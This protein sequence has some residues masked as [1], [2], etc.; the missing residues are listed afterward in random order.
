MLADLLRKNLLEIARAYAKAEKMPISVVSRKTYGKSSF[1]QDYAKAEK[2]LSADKASE[3]LD[4]FR[5]HWP[6]KAAWPI[7]PVIQ[8]GRA[9]R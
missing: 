2:T 8:M 1:L 5:D 9:R 6:D 4:W 3:M 7:L